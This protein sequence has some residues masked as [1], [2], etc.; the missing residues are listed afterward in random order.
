MCKIQSSYSPGSAG[1]FIIKTFKGI[2]AAVHDDYGE[3]VN[4]FIHAEVD[5]VFVNVISGTR[6]NLS[7]LDFEPGPPSW[8]SMTDIDIDLASA[9]DGSGTV[10]TYD[11]DDCTGS[12]DLQIASSTSG[13][14]DTSGSSNGGGGGGCLINTLF[15]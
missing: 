5:N 13:T 7:A 8:A 12:F 15:K 6:I 14:I 4:G 1:S 2:S 3:M 11:T 10:T 9:D